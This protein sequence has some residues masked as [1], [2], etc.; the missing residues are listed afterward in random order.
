MKRTH[1]VQAAPKSSAPPVVTPEEALRRK[2][3][4]VIQ[5]AKILPYLDMDTFSWRSPSPYTGFGAQ[6]FKK[7]WVT[8]TLPH[9]DGDEAPWPHERIPQTYEAPTDAQCFAGVLHAIVAELK[10]Q[11]ERAESVAA[12]EKRQIA[13]LEKRLTRARQDLRSAE[14]RSTQVLDFITDAESFVAGLTP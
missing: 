10:Y 9:E 3:M 12:E 7:G 1:T 5:A 2:A 6:S 11:R 8:L 13:E 4:A 14:E